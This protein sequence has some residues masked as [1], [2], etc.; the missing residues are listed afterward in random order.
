LSDGVRDVLQ[1]FFHEDRLKMLSSLFFL[2][3]FIVPHN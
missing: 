3:Y 1:L 2:L